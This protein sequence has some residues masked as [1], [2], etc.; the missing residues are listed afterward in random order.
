M[1]VYGALESICTNLAKVYRCYLTLV[2][3]YWQ[4]RKFHLL[5]HKVY[6]SIFVRHAIFY[7]KINKERIIFVIE[8][9]SESERQRIW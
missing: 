5:D 2:C 3:I 1:Y 9:K 8:R 6:I 7:Q 4:R